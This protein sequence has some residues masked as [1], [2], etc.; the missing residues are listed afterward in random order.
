M[1]S[2]SKKILLR[3]ASHFLGFMP[4]GFMIPLIRL[5]TL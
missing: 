2:F 4:D 3:K 1:P 5:V